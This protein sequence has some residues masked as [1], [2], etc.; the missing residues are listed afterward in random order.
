[1][2]K[3]VKRIRGAIGIGLTWAVGWAPV[4]AVTGLIAGVAGVVVGFPLGGIAVNYAELFAVLGFIGGSMFSTVLR[5]AEG[6]RRFDQLSLP[7]FAVWGAVGGLSLGT[8][9]VTLGV[10]G[11][12]GITPLTVAVVGAAGLLGAGS[13]TSSLVLARKADDRELLAAGHESADVGL[14]EA[15]RRE[16]LGS[17]S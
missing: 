5:I 4:G 14:S 6:Q 10:V 16:L 1:M 12:G 15:E 13:A 8:L 11:L 2:K 9:A 3:W 17:T 7:R